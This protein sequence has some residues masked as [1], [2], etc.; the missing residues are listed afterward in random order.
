MLGKKFNKATYVTS[1]TVGSTNYKGLKV[2]RTFTK[3][4]D[5]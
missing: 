5:L 1:S 2:L 4:V 3:L